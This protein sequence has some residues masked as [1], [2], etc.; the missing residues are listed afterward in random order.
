MRKRILQGGLKKRC[1]VVYRCTRKHLCVWLKFLHKIFKEIIRSGYVLFMRSKQ[2]LILYTGLCL[3]RD[4]FF[5]PFHLQMTRPPPPHLEYAQTLLTCLI[6]LERLFKTLEVCLP[7]T[8]AKLAKIKRTRANSYLY[9][10]VC[11]RSV[12]KIKRTRANIF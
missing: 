11:P 7:T 1:Y 9:T 3:P 10:I 12:A 6:D 8:R 2:I 5:A 4:I